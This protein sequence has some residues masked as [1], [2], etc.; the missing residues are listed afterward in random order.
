MAICNLHRGALI[1]PALLPIRCTSEILQNTQY[2]IF[3]RSKREGCVSEFFKCFKGGLPTMIWQFLD[4]LFLAAAKALLRLERA[5]WNWH[6]RTR[7]QT[8]KEEVPQF[9]FG[10]FRYFSCFCLQVM[11]RLHT[12]GSFWFARSYS[13]HRARLPTM[14]RCKVIH[15]CG[16]FSFSLLSAI[17][18]RGSR[19]WHFDC[20]TFF[21]RDLLPSNH[22]VPGY[23]VS[24][25]SIPSGLYEKS[26]MNCAYGR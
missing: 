5:T 6:S 14:I 26:K 24:F 1:L 20:L 15:I 8:A 10:I 21:L 18:L 17:S 25:S 22:F 23:P 2:N 16:G 7:H 3:V 19:L 12:L 9:C 13:V 4:A 11:Q